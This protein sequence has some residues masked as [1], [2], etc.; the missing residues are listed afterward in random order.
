MVTSI[1]EVH[2]GTNKIASVVGAS[3]P[4]VAIEGILLRLGG[5]K[6]F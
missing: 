5:S 1:D 2:A 4:T 6:I 3:Y